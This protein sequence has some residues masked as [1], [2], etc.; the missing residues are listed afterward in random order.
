MKHKT[1]IDGNKI[2]IPLFLLVLMLLYQQWQ[3]PTA[4]VYLALHGTYGILWVLKSNIF[5]DKTWEQQVSWLYGL[6]T[7]F[8]LCLYWVG[9]WIIFSQGVQAPAWW[10]G[11]CVSVYIFGVFLH[12]TADMQKYIS[13]RL[14]PGQLITDGLFTR[15]RNINYFGELLLYAGF[16][17]LAMH[18]LPIAILLLWVIVIWLPNIARK[19]RSLARYPEFKAYSRRT[20]R[21]V[22]FIY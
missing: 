5:P 18:W 13:L 1:F 11:F 3:N 8:G 16:G 17:L 14:N 12:F 6:A 4:C 15:V 2:L 9:G 7:W 22:P 10:L 21:F 19:E 20:K